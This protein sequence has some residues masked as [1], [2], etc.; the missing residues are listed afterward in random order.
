MS[1][2]TNPLLKIDAN[3]NQLQ[4]SYGELSFRGDY[5]GTNLIYK[6]YARP[7]TNDTGALSWQIA[8]LAYDGSNNLLSIKW[9]LLGNGLGDSGFNYD[10]SQR[11]TYTY[12]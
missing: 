10:W 5:T 11:A 6:G 12:V 8:K 4:N 7:G 3:Y 2:S 1:R 9:P